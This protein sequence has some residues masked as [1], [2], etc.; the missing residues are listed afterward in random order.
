MQTARPTHTICYRVAGRP[1]HVK[2]FVLAF[3]ETVAGGDV[4]RS[5]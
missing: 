3:A 5:E 4:D 2:I 1:D